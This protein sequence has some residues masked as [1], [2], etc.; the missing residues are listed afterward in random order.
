MYN[1]VFTYTPKLTPCTSVIEV[2]KVSPYGIISKSK[3]Q[4]KYNIK[5]NKLKL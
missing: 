5:F 2:D 3:K 1:L 4:T